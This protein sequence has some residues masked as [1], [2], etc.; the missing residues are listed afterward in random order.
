MH[1]AGDVCVVLLVE[2]TDDDKTLRPDEGLQERYDDDWK[3]LASKRILMGL[4]RVRR[5]G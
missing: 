4:D 1:G 2:M 5:L 3:F